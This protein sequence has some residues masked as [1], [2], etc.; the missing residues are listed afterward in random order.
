MHLSHQ[1]LKM[2][3]LSWTSNVDDHNQNMTNKMVCRNSTTVIIC[4]VCACCRNQRAGQSSRL[5]SD[6]TEEFLFTMTRGNPKSLL[7]SPIFNI[8]ALNVEKACSAFSSL[9]RQ[10]NAFWNLQAPPL[11]EDTIFSKHNAA[12]VRRELRLTL[13]YNVSSSTEVTTHVHTMTV[14]FLLWS[15]V[16]PGNGK[17]VKWV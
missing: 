1:R 10:H 12:Q 5:F 17:L 13:Y 2:K 15:N 8:A 14:Q 3:V 9:D 11:P 6:E 4:H 7:A 16:C